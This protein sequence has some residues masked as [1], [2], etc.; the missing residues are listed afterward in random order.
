MFKRRIP[1]QTQK[2]RFGRAIREA[3]TRCGLT[4]EELAEML[5][6][7]SHWVNNVELGKSNLNWRDTIYLMSILKLEPSDL[8][9]EVKLQTPAPAGRK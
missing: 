8:A 1:T 9:R 4:Q 5:E 7:S 2:E 3:R 6:C